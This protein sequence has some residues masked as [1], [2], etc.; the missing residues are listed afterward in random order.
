MKGIKRFYCNLKALISKNKYIDRYIN[1]PRWRVRISLFGTVSIN[2]MYVLIQLASGIVYSEAW[3][4]AL[5]VYYALL[6]VMRI[7]LI[8]STSS[9]EVGKNKLKE[10][11]RYRLCGIMLLIMNQALAIIVFYIVQQGMEF[12]NSYIPI[13]AMAA[14]TF[15]AMIVAIVNVVRYRRF[16]SPVMSAAKAIS[17]SSAVVSLLS[18]EASMVEAFGEQTSIGFRRRINA[19]TGA[20]VCIFVLTMAIYMIVR[21][22]KEINK[23]KN[24][25]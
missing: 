20:A 23:L 21:S 16:N 2:I 8:R 5:A 19:S 7:F 9:E 14:Y 4:Y 12:K 6:I 11:C 1:D 18:L 25:D 10:F 24:F 3:F 22:S 17:L 15:A 13:I